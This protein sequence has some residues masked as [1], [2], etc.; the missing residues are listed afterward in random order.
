M[1]RNLRL[2]SPSKR[3]MDQLFSI[4]E[5]KPSLSTSKLEDNKNTDFKRCVVNCLLELSELIRQ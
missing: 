2:N 1:E 3:N 5:S 4:K